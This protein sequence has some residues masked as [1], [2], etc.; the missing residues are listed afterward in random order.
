[1]P[2]KGSLAEIL[3]DEVMKSEKLVGIIDSEWKKSFENETYK[4]NGQKYTFLY[5]FA[6]V[7]ING[8]SKGKNSEAKQIL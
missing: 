5:F 1:M 6:L 4:L 7:L 8:L 3:I 2:L